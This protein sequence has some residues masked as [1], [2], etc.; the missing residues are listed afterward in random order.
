[1]S[2][3]FHFSERSAHVHT[4]HSLPGLPRCS[5]GL[6]FWTS[7]TKGKSPEELSRL[8]MEVSPRCCWLPALQPFA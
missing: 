3:Y 4:Q 6:E 2:E 8:F 5:P 7:A 1:M